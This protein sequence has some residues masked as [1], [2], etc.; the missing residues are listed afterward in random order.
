MRLKMEDMIKEKQ[1]EIVAV[2]EQ[3]DGNK[4]LV[5]TWKRAA[6]GGG[7]S[8]VLQDGNVFEKAGVNISVVY[9]DL[10]PKQIQQMRAEHKSL[11]IAD[12]SKDFFAA[13]LSMVLHPHNPNAPTV[14]LNYRYF[15]IINKDGTPD[16]WW[17][18]GGTDLT[19][20]YLFDEDA[21]HFHK[22]LKRAC[23]RHDPSYYKRFKEWCDRYFFNAHRNE[24]RGI[25]GIFFDDLDEKD[26][27]Q[28]L[29]FVTDCLGSFIPAYLPIIQKRKVQCLWPIYIGSLLTFYC[30]RTCRS[31]WRKRTGSSSAAADTSSSTSSMIAA[32]SSAFTPRTPGSS[33]SS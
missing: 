7:I 6:G 13:G 28:L 24:R 12:E 1:K 31:P 18:G 16:A 26:P 25:G 20:S 27:E 23:D 33:P 14:H 32:P 15:E 30:C 9:G 10:Q 19:P 29:T 4:F 21:I 3:V 8:C 22:T 11:G 5:D 2:L 17:F